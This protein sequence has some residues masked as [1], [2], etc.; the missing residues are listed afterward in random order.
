MAISRVEIKDYKKF[1][2]KIVQWALRPNT[3]PKNLAEFKK[4]T[5]GFVKVPARIKELEFYDNNDLEELVIKLPNKAMVKESLKR[6]KNPNINYPVAPFYFEKI[7]P[8][9]NGV[10][11]INML[12]SRIAD[13]TISQCM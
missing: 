5:A 12:Y 3:K 7:C 10:T 6:F 4:Q 8:E 1:G 13:Y 2:R 11:N 9:G